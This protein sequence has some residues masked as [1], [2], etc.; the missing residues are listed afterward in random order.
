M[1]ACCLW[2]PIDMLAYSY[3]APGDIAGSI[4]VCFQICSESAIS[5]KLQIVSPDLYIQLYIG[6]CRPTNYHKDIEKSSPGCASYADI[7]Q[8]QVCLLLL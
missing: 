1:I 8:A 2:L 3:H 6:V 5:H 7:H 4:C